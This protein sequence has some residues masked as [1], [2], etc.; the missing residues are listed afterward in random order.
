MRLLIFLICF[1]PA[2]FMAQKTIVSGKVGRVDLVLRMTH[3][4][5]GISPLGVRARFPSIFS[6]LAG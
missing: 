4:T 3:N 5:P 6:N 2:L 1:F